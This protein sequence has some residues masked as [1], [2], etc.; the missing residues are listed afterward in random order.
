MPKPRT[1]SLALALVLVLTACAAPERSTSPSSGPTGDRV[2]Q[3]TKSVT[4]GFTTGVQAMSIMGSS[5]TVGGYGVVFEI[6]SNGLVT[7]DVNSRAVVGRLAERAPSV[8]DGS[9][10]IL[11]DGRMR[12]V[13]P[14]RK[15]VRWQDGAPFTAHDLTFSYRLMVDQGIPS[16]LPE[17]VN[18]MSSV[19]ATDDFTFVAMFK[20]PYYLG[21]SLGLRR[22][23]P[24]PRHLLEPAYDRYLANKNPDEVTTLPYWT[25]EYVHLGPFRLTAFDPSEGME[26]RANDGY[27]LGRPKIDVLRIRSFGDENVLFS[28]LLSGAV[29]MLMPGA[30]NTEL[31]YQLKER[32]DSTGAGSIFSRPNGT[33]FLSPQERPA[34]QKEPAMLD[35]R[36]RA[37]LYHA[38][39][40]E[41]LSEGKGYNEHAA[42]SLLE[43]GHALYESTRDGLS[44]YAYNLDRARSI[45]RDLGWTPGSDGVLRNNADSRRLQTQLWATAGPR[46]WELP[47]FGDMW[48]RLGLDVEEHIVPSAQVRNNELR[49]T[50]PGW[51][52]SSSGG[53][54]STLGRLLGPAA[55]PENRWT[56]NRGGYE[57]PTAQTLVAR[58]YASL[59]LRDQLQA[60]K[61]VS[62]FVADSL[63]LLVTY[64]ITDYMGMRKGVN[65]FWDLE[66]GSDPGQPYG[67][68]SRNSHLWDIN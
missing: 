61:A 18:Q 29:D 44:R 35:V 23:W 17:G 68:Y 2:P 4:I 66:G 30:L 19:E 7:S 51:E 57:H 11:P 6:H 33:R 43:P 36:M 45:L 34:V 10:A 3:R 25:T 20:G 60:M 13:Y 15:D 8:E 5:T 39:D 22:F 62:D 27:F 53:G 16:N 21:G 63:P 64:Y 67:S 40:R 56:G 48:R 38:I 58:Y 55:G 31:G 26:F 42:W 28:H 9:I 14:L 1:A 65:A 24:Q 41:A 47:V 50:Y 37:A 32:W 49:A 54:D 12:V 59:S 46:A 52:P